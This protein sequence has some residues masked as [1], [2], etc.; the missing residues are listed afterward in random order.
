[1]V[2]KKNIEEIKAEFCKKY[3]INRD[4]A[5][6]LFNQTVVSLIEKRFKERTGIPIELNLN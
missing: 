5:G 4:E 6:A 1:M 2:T 3:N